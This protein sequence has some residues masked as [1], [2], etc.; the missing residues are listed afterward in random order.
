MA[1]R[2]AACRPPELRPDPDEP[3]QL[4]SAARR[5]PV[6]SPVRAPGV[7]SGL[8]RILSLTAGAA[9]MYCGRCLR[10]NALARNS[11]GRGTT[12]CSPIYTPTLTD[13]GNV[14]PGKGVLR[15]HQR[16]PPA[17]LPDLPETARFRRQAV[18]IQMGLKLATSGSISGRS[19]TARRDDCF[20]ASRARVA[21]RPKRSGS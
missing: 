10:D 12:S 21:F 6:R 19:E 20:D 2:L 3:D 15:R 4:G 5:Q 8:M 14:S 13:E 17:A 1:A 16:L 18:G 9:G 7:S 11:S